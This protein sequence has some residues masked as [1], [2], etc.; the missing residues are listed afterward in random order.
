MQG[1][2][3]GGASQMQHEDSTEGHGAAQLPKKAERQRG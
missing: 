1:G 2:G 3:T